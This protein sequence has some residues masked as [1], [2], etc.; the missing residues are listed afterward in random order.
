LLANNTPNAA[1]VYTRELDILELIQ[2]YA[3]RQWEVHPNSKKGR[4]SMACPIHNGDDFNFTVDED[5]KL[6]TCFSLCGGGNAYQLK[7]RLTGGNPDFKPVTPAKK[8]ST[9]AKPKEHIPFQGATIDQLAAAKGIDP[10][11]ARDVLQWEDTTYSN[12]QSDCRRGCSVCSLRTPAVHIPYF[13]GFGVKMFSRFRV[14]LYGNTERFRWE[15][16]SKVQ[17]YGLWLLDKARE[18]GYIVLVEGE[19]DTA[20]LN[21][22]GY[23]VLGIPGVKT[24]KSEWTEHLQGI[25]TIYA[26]Q[27]PEKSGQ[28]FITDLSKDIPNLRII[29]APP[30]AKDPCEL[31]QQCGDGFAG[32]IDDLMAKARAIASGIETHEF[33]TCYSTKPSKELPCNKSG[34]VLKTY[35]GTLKDKLLDYY[36][37]EQDGKAFED[38]SQCFE[39]YKQFVCQTTEQSFVKRMHCGRRGCSVCALWLLR[40]FLEDK[41]ELLKEHLGDEPCV[42]RVHLGSWRIGPFPQERERDLNDLYKQVRGWLT[43]MGD[44]HGKDFWAAKNCCYGIRCRLE[45][46]ITS[47]D[48]ILLTNYESGFDSLLKDHFSKR[49]G[50][51]V[52]VEELPCHGRRHVMESFVGFMAVPFVWDSTEDYQIWRAA[53]KGAKLIQGKGVF[54]KVVGGAPKKLSAKERLELGQHSRCPI[55]RNCEPQEVPGF[56]PVKSTQV[57]QVTSEITGE[58]YLEPIPEAAAGN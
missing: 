41:E 57:R 25:G 18:L 31:A 54:S 43:Q 56:L 32:F 55:C 15:K 52:K 23:P 11:H 14:G 37:E 9:P 47:F 46:E 36:K 10:N 20:T 53:T 3:P 13:D 50:I 1:T 17:P 34:T 35:L 4:Y 26:W 21:A 8:A 24:W 40:Q 58:V 45:G 42:Y 12:Y 44:N 49:T 48:L 6:F 33:R 22:T 27:E 19:T 2:Q 51:D 16:G 39:S 7:Q 28:D 5:R 38:V 29:Q 30:G